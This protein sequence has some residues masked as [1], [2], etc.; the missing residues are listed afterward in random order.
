MPFVLSSFV[1]FVRLRI[2]S[3]YTQNHSHALCFFDLSCSIIQCSAILLNPDSLRLSVISKYIFTINSISNSHWSKFIII[4]SRLIITTQYCMSRTVEHPSHQPIMFKLYTVS[5]YVKKLTKLSYYTTV[6]LQRSSYK[7]ISYKFKFTH[8]ILINI[9]VSQIQSFYHSTYRPFTH[10]SLVSLTRSVFKF[11]ILPCV[12]SSPL[13]THPVPRLHIPRPDF[14]PLIP[15][16]RLLAPLLAVRSA[17]PSLRTAQKVRSRARQIPL[18]D[19]PSSS[20]LPSPFL[21]QFTPRSR[22]HCSPIRR[23]PSDLPIS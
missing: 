9:F 2:S 7:L 18:L 22:M 10:I 16:P 23:P 3:K 8:L 12:P 19:R 14:T 17:Q 15:L 4:L 11:L 6:C 21:P 20:A 13:H 1:I 5:N